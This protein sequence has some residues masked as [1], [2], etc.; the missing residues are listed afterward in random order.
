MGA[1]LSRPSPRSGNRGGAETRSLGP[2]SPPGHSSND[3]RSTCRTSSRSWTA[4]TLT[5]NEASWNW[6]V[7]PSSAYRCC[8]GATLSALSCCIA[9]SNVRSARVRSLCWRR[10][11]TRPSSPSRTPGCSRSWSSATPQLTEALEQQTAT[12]EV[13]R[14]IASSPDRR[15]AGPGDDRPECDAAQRQHVGRRSCS[16]DGDYLIRHAAVGEAPGQSSSVG[17]QRLPADRPQTCRA[18]VPGA[19]HDPHRPM[20]PILPCA[21]SSQIRR[22]RAAD[23]VASSS[24][25]C[26][27]GRRSAC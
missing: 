5:R 17:R 23:R 24:R 26:A 27:S 11:L 13:L 1:E 22:H 16:R 15:S 8:L 7:A 12:A 6:D 9:R 14:V 10:S 25:S 4:S 19:S 21:S 2:T 18:G 20:D 3:G